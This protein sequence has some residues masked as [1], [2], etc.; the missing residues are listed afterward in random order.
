MNTT[1]ATSYRDAK[2]HYTSPKRR[3][4]VKTM[5]EEVVTHRVLRDAVDLVRRGPDEPLR[6]VDIGAGTGDGLALLTEP[7]GD[8]TPV[9][10]D[11]RLAYVG[12]DLDPGMVET[13]RSLHAGRPAE[14]EVADMRA[15]LP[16]GD[17][18]LYLSCGVPYSHLPHA[19]TIDVLTGLMRRIVETRDSAVMIVDVLGRYSVEW[20]PRWPET[21]WAYNMS[22][23]EGANETVHDQMSFYDRG[24]LDDALVQAAIGAGARLG[25]VTFTDRSV[26]VGRHTATRAFNQAIPPYRT[27]LN[28]LARGA[29]DV[30]PAQLRFTPPAG[31]VPSRVEA[32]FAAF[33][34]RWNGVLAAAGELRSPEQ[35]KRLAQALFACEQQ[36]QQG[37]GVGHSLMATVVVERPAGG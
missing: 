31:E 37:L 2:A 27:L 18:D 34:E 19:D 33:A 25:A 10:D 9:T 6:V 7:H 29:T 15:E 22:F 1:A 17:F 24:S 13:A 12:V 32:F 28:E 4:P 3:D 36:S 35:A 11:S 16:A 20:T 8:L 26:L 21:R 14:F 23:F 30:A 5:L